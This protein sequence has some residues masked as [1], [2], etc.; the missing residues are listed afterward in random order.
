MNLEYNEERAVKM[1]DLQGQYINQKKMFYVKNTG[2]YVNS[3]D[4]GQS[5]SFDA[6]CIYILTQEDTVGFFLNNSVSS[7]FIGPT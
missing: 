5:I 1:I 2:T 6:N 4:D 7:Y 3:G